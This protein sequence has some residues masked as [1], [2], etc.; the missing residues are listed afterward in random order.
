MSVTVDQ[1]IERYVLDDRFSARSKNVVKSTNA[2]A[3][4]VHRSNLSLQ[5]FSSILGRAGG[6]AGR[7]FS[8]MLLPLAAGAA[9]IGGFGY[10]A[11]N[12]AA[13]MDSLKR[14]LESVAGSSEEAKR[15]FIQLREVAKGPALGLEEAIKG[16][17][18]LQGAGLSAN[19]AAAALTQFGNALARSGGGKDELNGVIVAL[20]QMKGRSKVTADN[21]NQIANAFYGIRGAMKEVFGTADSE[22]IDK[23][24]IKAEEFIARITAHLTTLPRVT[25]GI[26]NAFDNL[27]DTGKIAFAQIGDA[28]ASKAVPMMNKLADFIAYITESGILTRMVGQIMDLFSLGGDS[29]LVHALALVV[30]TIESIP[31]HVRGIGKFIAKTMSM[32]GQIIAD[33]LSLAF[34][35]LVGGAVFRAMMA[36]LPAI[37][38]ITAAMSAWQGI[39]AAITAMVPGGAA[40]VASA[41][42][43]GALAGT[44]AFAISKAAIDGAMRKAGNFLPQLGVSGKG[45]QARA[46]ELEEGFAKFIGAPSA[47]PEPGGGAGKD[48]LRQIVRNTFETARNTREAVSLE[49]FGIGGGDLG[50]LGITPIELKKGRSGKPIDIRVTG[51]DESLN[52]L[53]SD[54]LRRALPLATAGRA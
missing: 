3:D 44:A 14:A 38:A 36:L 41:L 31:E 9:A 52:A 23:M 27:G 30:A 17:L 2:I 48:P 46:N 22:E 21:I 54:F 49:R 12:A 43:I 11:L 6:L 45:I 7:A 24:G 42:A 37:Q 32:A 51:A 35:L 8:G 19:E 18:A 15:Q 5:G 47:A 39:Q 10:A 20:A 13:D 40:L 4:S 28:L 25:G 26:R 16:S 33:V 29:A 1:V 53:L 50:S 34:G